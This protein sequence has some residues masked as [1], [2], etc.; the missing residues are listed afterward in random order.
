MGGH[1]ERRLAQRPE[2]TE[3]DRFELG[4]VSID[5]RQGKMAVGSGPAVSRHMLDNGEYAPAKGALNDGPTQGDHGLGVG[6]VGAVANDLV[7]AF[8]RY[9]E[10]G[11]GVDA[12]AELMERLRR[13]PCSGKGGLFSPFRVDLVQAAI[14]ACG[15][16]IL[17][18][19]RPQSLHAAQASNLLSSDTVNRLGPALR[20]VDPA[21]LNLGS[22]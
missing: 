10:N 15:R 18:I 17:P 2:G 5:A 21:I 16:H 3:I 6:A 7:C 22:Q 14:T 20:Q 12:D 9:V 4:G 19:G 1:G 11:H 8:L 13:Q